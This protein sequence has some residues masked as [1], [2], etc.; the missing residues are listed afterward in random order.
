MDCQHSRNK[1]PTLDGSNY[2]IWK[3]KMIMYIK[4]I[5]HRAW[6]SIIAGYTPPMIEVTSSTSTE[7]ETRE[8]VFVPKPEQNW[9][10]EEIALANFN[11]KAMGAIS[12]HVDPHMFR[13]FS[14]QTVAK[15]A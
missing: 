4:Y 3:A 2:T 9:T 7:G 5:D 8:R 15:T 12:D 6:V 1:P 10:M 13:L 11:A 14:N